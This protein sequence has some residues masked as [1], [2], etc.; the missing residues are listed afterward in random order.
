MP[1][2]FER[3]WPGVCDSCDT[4]LPTGFGMTCLPCR[5]EA[6]DRERERKLK[7]CAGCGAL[8]ER[9]GQCLACRVEGSERR[10]VRGV[11]L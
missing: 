5:R 11:R 1:R 6:T 10:L 4:E 2:R 3:R 9:F 7:R 8:S